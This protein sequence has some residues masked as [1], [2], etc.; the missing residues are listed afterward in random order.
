MKLVE[1]HKIKQSSKYYQLLTR[2]CKESN[3]LYNQALYNA[4]QSLQQNQQWLFYNDLNQ[5]CKNQPIKYNNYKRLPAQCSQQTLK[6]VDQNLKSYRNAIKDWSKNKAKYL[7]QPKLPKY[8]KSGGLFN[9]ILTNQQCKLNHYKIKFP[10]IFNGL[11]LKIR[12]KNIQKL[13]QIRICPKIDCFKIEI[14][15]EVEDIDLLQNNNYAAID[16]G[17]NNLLTIVYS[18]N[19]QPNIIK[20]NKLLAINHKFNHKLSKYKSIL[21]KTQKKQ[22][23]S[24]RLN[25]IYT[26]RNNKIENEMHK[27][28][29]MIIK[30]LLENN[31]STVIVGYNV[32]Q[33]QKSNLKNF[34]ALPIFRLINLLKYKCERVG[35]KLIE[36]NE[37]YTS[38]TSFLDNELPIKK[39]YDKSRRVNRGLFVSNKGK[40]LNSDINAAYQILRKY[41]ENLEVNYDNKIFNPRVMSVQ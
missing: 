1:I 6:I 37:S 19:K 31:I 28:T 13:N 33:K 27:I 8:R 34:V 3:S 38:G 2:L 15:Y 10:R 40:K 5:I 12:N 20:G 35:I 32:N 29:S 39:N 24:K 14:I 21:D 22:Y 26:K 30:K 9:L 7:G 4:K 41:N 18:N 36:V 11:M 25:R 17:L 16:L 23:N